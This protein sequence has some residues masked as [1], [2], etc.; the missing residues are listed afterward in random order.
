MTKSERQE[1]CINKW[2]NN[3]GRGTLN[4][5][6]RFGKTRVA[7]LISER[8]NYKVPDCKIIII[9]PNDI[10]LQNAKQNMVVN[11]NTKVYTFNSYL[12]HIKESG[13]HDE[14]YLLIIDEV[15]KLLNLDLYN[16]IALIKSKFM[17]ALTGAVLSK[18][19]NSKLNALNC[20]VI[21]YIGENEALKE[22]WIADYREYNLAVEL[23]E[24]EK[25]R[26][27]KFT[28]LISES[29]SAFNGVQNRIN[30][31]LGIKLFDSPFALLLSCFVGK[32]YKDKNGRT[33]FIKPTVLRNMCADLQGWNKDLD[34][35]VEYNQQLDKYWNPDNIYER[36]KIFKSYIKSRN[37]I[38]IHNRAKKDCVIKLLDR[39][40]LPTICFNE[41]I[42]MVDELADHYPT[43]GIPY[44]SAIESR[45][46]INK[47]TGDYYRT[48][49][50]E[51]KTFGKI[52][53][54][55]LAIEGM[56]NGDYKYLF[57]AKSLVEG[58]TIENIEMIITTGGS[59]NPNTH[60]QKVARGKTYDYANPNKV[61]IIVNL[62]IDDFK[63]DDKEVLS[64]DKKKLIMRQSQSQI[65]PI[66]VQN[67]EQIE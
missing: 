67:I 19:D 31:T 11:E 39:F 59:T 2:K 37:D 41:S 12:N 46:V 33:N 36:A 28:E 5:I 64:Q 34:M 13:N 1:I 62:Y 52:G 65:M 53:L 26:Y 56:K 7:Q 42:A 15:H 9:V 40:N 20:P 58:T 60:D 57:T 21:D 14:C 55:K 18:I 3:L 45:Y 38:L 47:E 16:H 32:T 54:K 30:T 43:D 10:T 23:D 63:I 25:E 22:K 51:P 44:H 35:T 61:C 4:L 8:C 66:W 48:L 29:L 17:L 24:N 6:M 49:K 50:G 27:A